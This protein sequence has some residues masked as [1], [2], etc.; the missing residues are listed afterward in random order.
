MNIESQA[1]RNSTALNNYR[2]LHKRTTADTKAK[3]QKIP[4]DSKTIKNSNIYHS[5]I[6]NSISEKGE[7]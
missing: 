7:E 2:L 3:T 5:N 6:L 1:Q 4:I